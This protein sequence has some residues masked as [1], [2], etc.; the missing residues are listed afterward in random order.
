MGWQPQFLT[1]AAL[2]LA[3][4]SLSLSLS[5]STSF[6][7]SLSLQ[8]SFL[9]ILS[10]G[11]F[12]DTWFSS[13]PICFQICLPCSL[14]V[15]SFTPSP[16]LFFSPAA[17]RRMHVLA[18]YV[19]PFCLP[20]FRSPCWKAFLLFPFSLA[21]SSSLSQCFLI[22]LLITVIL[23]GC[24]WDPGFSLSP[25]CSPLCPYWARLWDLWVL[26][27]DNEDSRVSHLCLF[28][29]RFVAVLLS[30]FLFVPPCYC[31]PSW[32]LLGTGSSSSPIC[33]RVCSP[34]CPKLVSAL[35]IAVLCCYSLWA[36]LGRQV[37]LVFHLFPCFS[38]CYLL[39][40]ALVLS[41]LL[42]SFCVLVAKD[43]FLP[44]ICFHTCL[45]VCSQLLSLLLH[46]H[47]DSFSGC[48][49]SKEPPCL[50]FLTSLSIA[51]CS[52]FWWLWGQDSPCVPSVSTLV[53]LLLSPLWL[54]A[55]SVSGAQCAPCP[56]SVSVLVPLVLSN[57]CPYFSLS[58]SVLLSECFCGHILSWAPI[59]F[60][61]CLPCSPSCI[62]NSLPIAILLS[63]CF[64][65]N[66][67]PG[68]LCFSNFSSFV[69][70]SLFV[71]HLLCLS[72][73]C[74][75]CDET[76]CPLHSLS[77]R[78]DRMLHYL[79]ILGSLKFPERELDIVK[80]FFLNI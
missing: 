15:V 72:L 61:T 60:H 41:P 14:Q 42:C 28:L 68:L 77:L 3:A 46:L 33:F 30:P 75:L 9:L 31:S 25:M 39:L 20:L 6:S 80:H 32:V 74:V 34:C 37:L 50:P 45:L 10:L 19:L 48:F 63:G 62:L 76:Y 79:M 70:I 78:L 26:L 29:P 54:F 47:C 56:L 18:P 43:F 8:L 65:K 69:Q 22:S 23:A 1:I 67:F 55:L 44:P 2:S 21:C 57:S 5:P 66:E 11:A 64:G 71:S 27:W 4:L 59:C 38:P 35:S 16:L 12:V 17:L 52:S 58:L 49:R 40:V 73:L 51:W 53:S 24:F 7:P 36:L 13:S